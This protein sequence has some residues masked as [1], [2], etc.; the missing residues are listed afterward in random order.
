MGLG[1]SGAGWRGGEAGKARGF[2]AW[3]L[4]KLA[5]SFDNDYDDGTDEDAFF[6]VYAHAV[7]YLLE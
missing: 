5:N 7:R 6:H 3:P 2:M 4:A 1:S